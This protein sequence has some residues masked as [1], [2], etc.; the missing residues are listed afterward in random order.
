MRY[1]MLDADGDY[2]MGKPG[3]F[4][5]DSPAAVAQA[6]LTRLRLMTGEWF[7]D[8]TEGT[9]YAEEILGFSPVTGRDIAIQSRI[10]GTPGVS[11]ITNYASSLD[12]SNRK[13]SVQAAIDTIYGP[14]TISEVL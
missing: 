1:R 12:P 9:P 8:D 4:L 2:V 10:N 5:V 11:G 14:A 13:M 3:E 6:C 7:L